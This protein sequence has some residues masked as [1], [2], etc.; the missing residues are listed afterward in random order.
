MNRQFSNQNPEKIPKIRIP[1]WVLG[2]WRGGFTLLE[3]IV[4]IG[5]F[6]ILVTAAIGVMISISNAQIKAVNN[7]ITQD[8]IR[9]SMELMTKE[10]RTG[11]EYTL[12]QPCAPPGEG[13]AFLT[14]RGQR[15]IYF[16]SGSSIMRSVIESD[17]QPRPEHCSDAN[18][19]MAEEVSAERV[20]FSVGGTTLG[21]SDGQPWAMISLSVR[22]QSPQQTLESGMNLQTTV[23]QRLRDIQQ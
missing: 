7:Q 13:L 11:S 10:I 22:S 23:V 9:F 20:H 15:R 17:Q 4:S 3:M 16:L 1:D 8:N 6:S 2:F 19:L 18:P 5:I 14:S 21:S 12:S